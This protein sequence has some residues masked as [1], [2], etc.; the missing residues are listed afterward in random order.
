MDVVLEGCKPQG[1]VAL[2]VTSCDFIDDLTRI[3]ITRQYPPPV[4]EKP[5]DDSG[6]LEKPIDDSAPGATAEKPSDNSTPMAAEKPKE[7]SA[8]E[9]PGVGSGDGAAAS[10]Y[11]GTVVEDKVCIAGAAAL[12][13]HFHRGYVLPCLD[14]CLYSTS[15]VNLTNALSALVPCKQQCLQQAPERQLWYSS[16]CRQGPGDCSRQTDQ[17]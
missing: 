1:L 8:V 11:S 17:Q 5:V 2:A 9:K 3:S 10:V 7:G 16:G 13:V 15:P 4:L 6:E 12:K 14:L